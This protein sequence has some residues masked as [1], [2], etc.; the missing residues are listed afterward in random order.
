MENKKEETSQPSQDQNQNQNQNQDQNQNQNQEQDQ[1]QNQNQ[2]QDQNQTPPT[3]SSTPTPKIE[4]ESD[5]KIA[6][7][8]DKTPQTE[9]TNNK[10]LKP[11]EQFENYEQLVDEQMKE[12]RG[13]INKDNQVGFLQPFTDLIPEFES[14]PNFLKKIKYMQTNH[15][16]IF[17]RRIRKDGSCFYRAFLFGL[18]ENYFFGK[19]DYQ[20]G[21][22]SFANVNLYI[23]F[24]ICS[25]YKEEFRN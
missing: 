13:H 21:K 5:T 3:D 2:E 6:E 11:Y 14:S 8:A 9:S 25:W 16:K 22:L 23:D 7:E 19:I 24:F 12:I 17:L 15:K 18:A 4:D 20:E 10:D 1:N